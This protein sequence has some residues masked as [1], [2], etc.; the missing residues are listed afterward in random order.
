MLASRL[1]ASAIKILMEGHNEVMVGVVNNALKITPL[2][3][4]VS[5]KK[6]LDYGLV[7]LAHVLR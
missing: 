3:V 4:A 2:R 6:G 7:E 1:G 5:K